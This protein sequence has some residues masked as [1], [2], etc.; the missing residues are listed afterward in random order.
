MPDSRKDPALPAQAE[1]PRQ[2]LTAYLDT[3]AHLA[4]CESDLLCDPACTRPGCRNQDLQVQ[5]SII[6]LLA[7]ARHLGEAVSAIYP[8]HYSLG[9]FANDRDDWIRMVS[10]KLKKP[11]PFLANDLCGIYPVRPL[12]CIL[13]PEYLVYQ[14][15]FQ[16]EA[17]KDHFQGYLCLQRPLLLSPARA[18]IMGRLRTM[19]ERESLIS[20]FYLFQH[21]SCHLDFS[22]LQAE[23][24]VAAGKPGEAAAPERPEPAIIPNQV[25]ERFFLERLAACGPFAGVEEKIQQLCTQ[26]GQLQ[27]LRLFEDERLLTRLQREGDGRALVFK[28]V[29]GKLRAQRRSLLPAE[30]KYY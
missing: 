5:V 24:L 21:G 16:E 25:L 3:R 22:N 19:W 27:F 10:P 6:D 26:E 12:P 13:F 14:G 2:G 7:A 9:L 18:K 1:N 15:R 8:R 23:L 17:G 11:C 30:Y 28:F 29:K 20:S 4:S